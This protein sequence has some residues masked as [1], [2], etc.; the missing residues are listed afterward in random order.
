MV[1]MEKKNIIYLT[2]DFG[3]GHNSAASAIQEAVN[4]YYPGKFNQET[5][6]VVSLIGPKLDKFLEKTFKFTNLYGKLSWKAFFEITDK[7]EA[8]TLFDKNGYPLLKKYLEPILDENPDIIISCYPFLAYSISRFLKENKK[9]IPL[10]MVVT[11]TGDVHS[12][13][14]N[15]AVDHYLVQN[16]ETGFYLELAG[17]PKD[18]IHCLGFALRQDFYKRYDKQKLRKKLKIRDNN[19]LIFY[20]N[21]AWGVGKLANKVREIDK[22]LRGVSIIVNCGRNKRLQ[23]KLK[24]EKYKNQIIVQGFVDNVAEL[25]QCSDL[26]ISKA[27][28]ASIMEVVTSKTPVVVTEVMPGQEEPNARFIESKGFG[29]VEKDPEKLAQIVKY[30]LESGDIERLKRNLK[31]Y[32]LNDGAD[33]KVAKYIV[34]LIK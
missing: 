18:K 16:Q 24:K 6:D 12:A 15:S 33:K 26:I 32:K 34:G 23:D 11:D 10:V 9:K 29:Y 21:G 8:V 22:L 28:G 25:L 27:G 2:T 20:F 3:S 17:V 31:N 13:W 19:K 7:S 30:I 5:I 1:I 14:I 4:K